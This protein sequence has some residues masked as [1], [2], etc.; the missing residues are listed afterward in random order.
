[1]CILNQILNSCCVQCLSE[2]F[3]VAFNNHGMNATHFSLTLFHLSLDRH[4]TR[5]AGEVAAVANNDICGV[6]VAYNAKIGGETACL[7]SLFY[8][9]VFSRLRM[10][11]FLWHLS[12]PVLIL[13]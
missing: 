10:S 1:M 7:I 6:G 3:Y 4:G 12:V 5:C 2:S 8:S 9:F 11:K 13:K